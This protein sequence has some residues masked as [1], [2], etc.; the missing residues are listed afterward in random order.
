[1]HQPD[2]DLSGYYLPV[3]E[4]Q[5]GDVALRHLFV[6]AEPDFA[7]WEAG[8]RRYPPVALRLAGGRI[9]PTAYSVSE[10]RIRLEGRHDGLGAVEFDGRLDADALAQ[11]RRAIGSRAVVLTGTLKA[12]GQ[13][14]S[15]LRFTW[16]SGE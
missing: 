11:A 12:G 5:V 16:S 9:V 14:H 3:G 10:G 15:G 13:T 6:A 8:E 7:D 1:S 2:A 4:P